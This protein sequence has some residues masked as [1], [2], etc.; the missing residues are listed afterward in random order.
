MRIVASGWYPWII[1]LPSWSRSVTATLSAQQPVLSWVSVLVTAVAGKLAPSAAVSVPVLAAFRLSSELRVVRRHDFRVRCQRQNTSASL[2]RINAP[3]GIMAAA[4]GASRRQSLVDTSFGKI[5]ITAVPTRG[6]I[7]YKKGIDH[8]IIEPREN[9]AQG[10]AVGRINRHVVG[11]RQGNGGEGTVEKP[12]SCRNEAKGLLTLAVSSSRRFFA[13]L[14]MTRGGFFNS[15]TEPCSAGEQLLGGQR[16]N[17]R[18]Q[19]TGE[20]RIALSCR[21]GLPA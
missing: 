11:F 8:A 19:A 4:G 16:M 15:P 6:P 14:R 18:E 12:P 13:A 21:R 3:G 20:L 2:P 10:F 1:T 7:N 17:R 9:A 5:I